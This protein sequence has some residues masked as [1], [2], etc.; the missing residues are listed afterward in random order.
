RPA[1]VEVD[2][3]LII[4]DQVAER[5]RVCGG[6]HDVHALAP[7]LQYRGK[8]RLRTRPVPISVHVRGDHAGLRFLELIENPT[9]RILVMGRRPELLHDTPAGSFLL[10]FAHVL[11]RWTRRGD[12]VPWTLA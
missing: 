12:S 7:S 9:H 3:H 1:V 4:I 5:Y 2:D 8:L 6:V 10:S 11:A